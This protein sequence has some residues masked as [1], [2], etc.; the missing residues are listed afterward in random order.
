MEYIH[1]VFLWCFWKEKNIPLSVKEVENTCAHFGSFF[2]SLGN[3]VRKYF[4]PKII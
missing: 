3:S 2:F 1:N 4:N